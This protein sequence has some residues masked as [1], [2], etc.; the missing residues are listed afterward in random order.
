MVFNEKRVCR[1]I[2]NNPGTEPTSSG[3]NQIPARRGGGYM[4]KDPF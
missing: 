3:Q 4:N 2:H 1:Q